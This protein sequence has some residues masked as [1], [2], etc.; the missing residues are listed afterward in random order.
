MSQMAKPY[1][2]NWIRTRQSV[3][4]LISSFSVSG[5]KVD[6]A[7]ALAA[8]GGDG[9]FRRIDL[10]TNLR[11]NRNTMVLNKAVGSDPAEEF[12]NVS[13]PL[14]TLDVLQA[15]TQEHMAAVSGIPLVKL[16]G[17]SPAGLNA[18]SEGE[19]RTFYD[20]IHAYQEKFF[21]THLRTVIDLIQLSEFG[22]VDEDIHVSFEP[23]WSL[24]EKEAA[25]V[26]LV[27]AQ[28]DQV[29]IDASIILPEEARKRVASDNDTVYQGLD[30][31]LDIAPDPTELLSE[32]PE[33]D[34]NDEGR[35]AAE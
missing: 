25:E 14:G 16:L 12:F 21:G 20:M 33:P 7:S 11:D 19:I 27:E 23:L 5:I 15:Q 17:I 22:D 28:T 30:L 8:D 24:D 3:A 1:V 4:D 6:M 29:L 34:R 13:T 35:E 32:P 31:S 2:D 26:R 10:F 9:L 18:S